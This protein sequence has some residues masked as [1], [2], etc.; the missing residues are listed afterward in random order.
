MG[1]SGYLGNEIPNFG[2]L[3]R[4]PPP[5]VLVAIL[6]KCNRRCLRLQQ[7]SE[8]KPKILE[9]IDTS[10]ED[11]DITNEDKEVETGK[12]GEESVPRNLPIRGSPMEPQGTFV[13]L[14]EL[15]CHLKILNGLGGHL[16]STCACIN[17]LSL[18]IINYLKE[19]VSKLKE[20]PICSWLVRVR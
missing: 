1:Q 3:K 7:K 20:N 10:E 13:V 2:S 16:T 11:K 18:E 9:F 4:K 14:G 12:G 8:E 19:V 6:A 17:L 5:R 15:R